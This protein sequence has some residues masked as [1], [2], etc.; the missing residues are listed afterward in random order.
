[1]CYNIARVSHF[2]GN[3]FFYKEGIVVRYCRS[4]KELKIFNDIK[5]DEE[6][7]K[8][9]GPIKI[10]KLVLGVRN[11]NLVD[12]VSNRI[13]LIGGAN[14]QEVCWLY[15]DMINDLRDEL[16][17]EG[18]IR[19][20][21]DDTVSPERYFAEMYAVPC[22]LVPRRICQPYLYSNEVYESYNFEYDRLRLIL[23]ILEEELPEEQFKAV[24][25]DIM[26]ADSYCACSSAILT[27][28]KLFL[29]KTTGV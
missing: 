14:D 9:L 11:D 24:R 27:A 13:S 19:S 7:L 21:M 29:E 4:V 5:I 10:D 25:S 18:F 17:V 20:D 23:N 26:Y 8:M 3:L 12:Y 22:G 15:L 2:G 6:L 1:M 16:K 28:A